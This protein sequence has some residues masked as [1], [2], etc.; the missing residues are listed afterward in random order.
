MMSR[1]A[2]EFSHLAEPLIIWA[3]ENIC[4]LDFWE[5]IRPKIKA[6]DDPDDWSSIKLSLK[7]A[8]DLS[9]LL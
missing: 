7:N 6:W 5:K 1:K 9:H 8:I 4:V 3:D 2:A